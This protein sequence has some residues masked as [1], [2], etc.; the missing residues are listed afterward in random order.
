[1]AL[2]DI[3]ELK[4]KE[5]GRVK[6]KS[7]IDSGTFSNVHKVIFDFRSLSKRRKWDVGDVVVPG[8]MYRAENRF[9]C[10]LDQDLSGGHRILFGK[11]HRNPSAAYWFWRE[12]VNAICAQCPE[13]RDLVKQHEESSVHEKWMKSPHCYLA[14]KRLKALPTT[15][16]R[17]STELDFL[18]DH[19]N[20]AFVP[21]LLYT[22]RMMSRCSYVLPL[23]DKDK[24]EVYHK[25]MTIWHIYDFFSKL[26]EALRDIHENGWIHRDIKPQN[27]LYTLPSF[28][29]K[30]RIGN[31]KPGK[32]MHNSGRKKLGSGES[33]GHLQ[34]VDFGLS[35]KDDEGAAWRRE[36]RKFEASFNNGAFNRSMFTT[37][38]RRRYTPNQPRSSQQKRS[39]TFDKPAAKKRRITPHHHGSAFNPRSV[40]RSKRSR[41]PHITPNHN[42]IRT[43]KIK[44]VLKPRKAEPIV[45]KH[46][47]KKKKKMNPLDRLLHSQE[48]ERLKREK[49]EKKAKERRERKKLIPSKPSLP[50]SRNISSSKYGSLK[51]PPLSKPSLQRRQTP[52]AL[53]TLP[54]QRNDSSHIFL[55]KN[56]YSEICPNA[57]R[58]GTRGFRAPEVLLKSKRQNY[59]IDV[60]SAGVILLCF[61]CGHHPF[62]H[63]ESDA[64]NIAE[65]AHICGRK[66]LQDCA[67]Y[68][69]RICKIKFPEGT[70]PRTYPDEGRGFSGWLQDLVR[71]HKDCCPVHCHYHWRQWPE[72]LN[73]LLDKMLRVNNRD[74]PS[75]RKLLEEDDFLV[76][77]REGK[78][79]TF[80]GTDVLPEHRSGLKCTC[81]TSDCPDISPLNPDISPKETSQE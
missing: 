23:V 14:V 8:V 36:K 21:K 2:E 47:K 41:R 27:I 66:R 45:G 22:Q 65:I 76:K 30:P 43:K 33:E 35:E 52:T 29:S 74:R 16:D 61:M 51:K 77:M 13:L 69:S 24:F 37:Q 19:S 38:Q 70:R 48:M 58:A 39:D 54:I 40:L 31:S 5:F 20:S 9:Q 72:E 15:R 12:R 3:P 68:N 17:K 75:A 53:A 32:P 80:N 44:T 78:T 25:R 57:N 18:R 50:R 4:H 10:Y 7:T 26:L 62:F 11:E 63:A 28:P 81:C 67:K 1:M 6:I 64:M 56:A 42:Q 59:A 71:A 55:A 79:M 60:W 46:P 73:L 49:K 34:I